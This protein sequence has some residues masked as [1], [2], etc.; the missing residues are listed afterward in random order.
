MYD[1]QV[2][3]HLVTKFHSDIK[4]RVF[5]KN[6]LKYYIATYFASSQINIPQWEN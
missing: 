6:S 3:F 1:C 2:Q 5:I 4:L